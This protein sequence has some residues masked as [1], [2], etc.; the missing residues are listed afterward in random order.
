MRIVT[1]MNTGP[2]GTDNLALERECAFGVPL[3]FDFSLNATK[4]TAA[5]TKV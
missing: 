1:S 5:T 3:K 4:P 2:A